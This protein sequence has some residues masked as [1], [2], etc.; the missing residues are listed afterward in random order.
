LGHK[1]PYVRRSGD[2]QQPKVG[3]AGFSTAEWRVIQFFPDFCKSWIPAFAGMTTLK[4][5]FRF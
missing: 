5:G 4:G 3:Q 1:T 2:L